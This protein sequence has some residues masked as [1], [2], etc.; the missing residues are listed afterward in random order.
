MDEAWLSASMVAFILDICI[1]EQNIFKA[2]LSFTMAS[3]TR[4]D[5]SLAEDMG[6]DMWETRLKALVGEAYG[7]KVNSNNG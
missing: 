6:R 1:K 3:I 5:I 4:V 2:V 7:A